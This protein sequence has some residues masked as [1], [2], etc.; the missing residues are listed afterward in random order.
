M[1]TK[2]QRRMITE[3]LAIS[4]G[5]P[6]ERVKIGA[7]VAKGRKIV[8]RGANSQSSHPLQRMYNITNGREW[9]ARHSLHAELAAILSTRKEK[10]S[11]A[12]IYVGRWDRNG[13]LAMCRPCPACMRALRDYGVSTVTYTTP[14]G[15]QHE[16]VTS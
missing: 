11:G 8:G 4:T 2:R 14:H 15:I 5:S 7:V 16:V 3:A 1:I 6:F 13:R 9:A 12:D 10:L